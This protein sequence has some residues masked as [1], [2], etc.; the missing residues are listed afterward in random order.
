MAGPG[1]LWLFSPQDDLLCLDL[2]LCFQTAESLEEVPIKS[3]KSEEDSS[4]I[5]IFQLPVDVKQESE[6]ASSSGKIYVLIY[7]THISEI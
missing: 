1:R 3:P 7:S 5:L 2:G 6:E 4:D